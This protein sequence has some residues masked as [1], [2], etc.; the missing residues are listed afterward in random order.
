M[1]YLS[2]SVQAVFAASAINNFVVRAGVSVKGIKLDVDGLL[3]KRTREEVTKWRLEILPQN[4]E[5]ALLCAVH[6]ACG[7]YPYASFD[8]QLHITLYTLL[9]TLVDDFNVPPSALE[10]FADRLYSGQTQLHPILDHLVENLRGMKKYYAPFLASL[11][12]KSTLGLIDTM[13]AETHLN[14]MKLRPAALN[15]VTS[16]RLANGVGDAYAC[17]IWDK[18]NFPDL[19]TFIQTIPYVLIWFSLL[20]LCSN[21]LSQ[22]GRA[23]L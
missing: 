4:Y 1:T 9:C 6:M 7:T 3:E 2:L 8:V 21:A 23:R 15:Y 14:T 11:I 20:V 10:Q 18:Y 19:S 22:R 13:A 12:V 17:F 16:R 5:I